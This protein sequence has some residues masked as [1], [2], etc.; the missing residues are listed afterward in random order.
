MVGSYAPKAEDHSFKTGSFFE[1][2][3]KIANVSLLPYAEL[4]PNDHREDAPLF[5]P[6]LILISNFRGGNSSIWYACERNL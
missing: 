2:H 5:L 3:T 6:T 4:G 1:F